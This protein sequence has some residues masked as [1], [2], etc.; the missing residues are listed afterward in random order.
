MAVL[1]NSVG[2]ALKQGGLTLEAQFHALEM[3][4]NGN[5]IMAI[6][7]RQIVAAARAAFQMRQE[8]PFFEL[9]MIADIASGA[10][11]QDILQR[12]PS[13]AMKQEES[14]AFDQLQHDVLISI[15]PPSTAN[16]RDPEDGLPTI[17]AIFHYVS[18]HLTQQ[19]FV[20]T[21][22]AR[23]SPCRLYTCCNLRLRIDE[24]NICRS[25]PWLSASWPNWGPD[26]KC[27]YGTAVSITKPPASSSQAG[28]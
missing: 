5:G 20:E 3:E 10:S 12:I 18:L 22:A 14:G 27:W 9:A 16:G 21:S 24:P 25:K 1:R 11:V 6:A 26:G 2:V 17:H 28:S 19:G 23:S 4:F 8:D 15:R 7:M 13:C